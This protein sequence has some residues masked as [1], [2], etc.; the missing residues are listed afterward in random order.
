MSL[1][2]FHLK[3]QL[4]D[5][6]F[7]G[8]S[9]FF[10]K[11]LGSTHPKTLIILTQVCLIFMAFSKML[12]CPIFL[13]ERQPPILRGTEKKPM[14]SILNNSILAQRFFKKF[15]KMTKKAYFWPNMV[16]YMQSKCQL[17]LFLIISTFFNENYWNW[18]NIPIL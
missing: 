10:C 6:S 2:L 14:W 11:D 3:F 13:S 8:I 16:N 18:N 1:K 17:C 12:K 4:S 7:Q 9:N 5:M 15:G